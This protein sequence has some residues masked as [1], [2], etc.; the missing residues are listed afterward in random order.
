MIDHQEAAIESEE[1]KQHPVL[2]MGCLSTEERR[3]PP[4]CI[5]EQPIRQYDTGALEIENIAVKVA[6]CTNLQQS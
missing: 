4:Y 6:L 5:K 2:G 3:K 1:G